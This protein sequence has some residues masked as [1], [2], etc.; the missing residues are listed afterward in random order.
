VS[1][2]ELAVCAEMV[3]VDLPITERVRRIADLGS[4]S[5]SGTG[6]Q[7]TSMHWRQSDNAYNSIQARVAADRTIASSASALRTASSSVAPCGVAS[8][9]LRTN[10]AASMTLRSS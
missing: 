9:M 8:R 3:F 4:A 7:K 6:R 5:S 10:A 2:I 1:D